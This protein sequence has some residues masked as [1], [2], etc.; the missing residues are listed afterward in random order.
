MLSSLLTG[1]VALSTV[2]APPKLAVHAVRFYSPVAG[3][4]SVLAFVQV[5]YSLAEV[6]G[7]RVAWKTTI[8]VQDGNGMTIHREELWRGAPAVMKQPGAYGIEPLQ[9]ALTA[10]GKYTIMATVQ[11]S[12]TGKTASAQ[13]TVDAYGSSPMVSD[14]LLA[15]SMRIAA[16]GDAEMAP[17]EVG[18]GR[19]RFVT[20]PDLVL[21]GLSPALSFLVEVYSPKAVDVSTTLEVRDSAGA[22]IYAIPAFDQQVGEGGGVIRG[23]VP[24]DGLPEGGYVLRATVTIGSQKIER[25][26]RFWVGN[27]EEALARQAGNRVADQLTDEGYFGSL[28]EDQ[29]DRA[30]EA[31]ELIASNRELSVYKASGDGRLSLAAKRKFLV[32]FWAQRDPDKATEANE[33]RI[34]FYQA[35]DYANTAFAETGRNARPGWKTDRGRVW[36]RNGGA[37]SELRSQPQ[38]G[39]APPYEIWRYTKGRMRYYVFADR[40]NL[41]A[42]S[43]MKSNDLKEPGNAAWIEIMTPEAVRD[44]GQ[45]L[46]INLFETSPGSLLN[47]GTP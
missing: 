35:I 34:N 40:N 4:T 36:A 47:T 23:T 26:G 33:E 22:T 37:P 44:I 21:N 24:L 41:G 42:F 28:S 2:V 15:S 6:A 20:A 7:D 1:L 13:T 29:L 27:L 17:G 3:Q 38:A 11:D 19:L 14:L 8:E 5:P 18:R 32:D 30:A 43:L 9:F 31:L 45:F 39:R 25:S 12:A 16:E 10:R 46:G